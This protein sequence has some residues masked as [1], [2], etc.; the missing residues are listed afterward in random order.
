MIERMKFYENQLSELLITVKYARYK[1][2]YQKR[3]DRIMRK[4]AI[5]YYAINKF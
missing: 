2:T 1:G 5:I 4:L 3:I